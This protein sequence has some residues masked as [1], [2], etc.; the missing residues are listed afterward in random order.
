M[1]PEDSGVGHNMWLACLAQCTYVLYLMC[2]CE[3]TR[4]KVD[5]YLA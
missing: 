3:C 2:Y 5:G 4:E 1:H